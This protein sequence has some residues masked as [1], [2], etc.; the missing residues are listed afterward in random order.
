[1]NLTADDGDAAIVRAIIAMAKSLHLKTV[2]EG[3]ETEAQFAMLKA[4]GCELI[5][6]FLFSRPV[7]A[8]EMH[9]R[10]A[11]GLLIAVA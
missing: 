3:V 11:A 7:P 5:Q 4:E 8:D 2:A 10:I 6:G 9:R 1:M